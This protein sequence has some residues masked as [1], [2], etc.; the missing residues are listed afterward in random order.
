[1][2]RLAANQGA[3]AAKLKVEC[4]AEGL[5]VQSVREDESYTLEITPAMISLSAP[6]ALRVMHGLETAL[7]LLEKDPKAGW[8][9]KACTIKDAPRFAWRG[10]LMDVCR[11]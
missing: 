3:S 1:M 6:N 2:G 8:G 7:Q 5:P 9:F 10:L 11:H 4:K